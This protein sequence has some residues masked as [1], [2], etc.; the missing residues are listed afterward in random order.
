MLKKSTFFICGIFFC[1]Q[2]IYGA[3]P[4]LA[5]NI[6]ELKRIIGSEELSKLGMAEVIESIKKNDNS[7]IIKSTHKEMHVEVINLPSR[8][9]PV[10]FDL[11]F[12][13]PIVL[14][15]ALEEKKPKEVGALPPLAQNIA[16]LKAVFSNE[17]MNRL[18]MA[19]IFESLKKTD[20][21]YTI[22]TTSK[23][24]DVDVIYAAKEIGPLKFELR[25]NE[26]TTRFTIPE[27]KHKTK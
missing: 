16:E 27:V 24:M 7:Y 23:K 26:P 2:A 10:K 6:A 22:R 9:G 12:S 13:E 25:F 21:G 17:G 3:L 14:S 4:P 11:A 5:Q 19:E 8:V 18:G 1:V 15:P 20:V